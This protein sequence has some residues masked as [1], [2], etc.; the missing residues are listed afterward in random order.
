MPLESPHELKML[1]K[2]LIGYYSNDST[3]FSYQLAE[4]TLTLLDE[5]D[6]LKVEF[7]RQERDKVAREGVMRRQLDLLRACERE[8]DELQ[9]EVVKLRGTADE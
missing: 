1:A 7:A 2:H 5:L 8:R 3:A 4:G 9:K 6:A